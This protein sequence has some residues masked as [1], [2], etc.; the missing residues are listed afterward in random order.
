M[1]L[2]KRIHAIANKVL[3][4]QRVADI[5]TDHG[6]VPM[7]LVRNGVTSDVIM[8]DI[9]EGSLSKAVETFEMCKLDIE[10]DRFRVGDGLETIEEGEADCVIIAGL[11]GFT[12]I[13]ILSSSIDKAK[14]FDRLILQPRK[15]SGSLRYFLYANGWDIVCE[16]LAPEGKFFC[17]I[18]VAEPSDSAAPAGSSGDTALGLRTPPYPEDDIRWLYPKTMVT[19]SPYYA[20]KR[21][22]WKLESIRGEIDNLTKSTKDYS[23]L[24][25]KLSADISYLENLYKLAR[26]N[27]A[28]CEK[29][30][31]TQ[32]D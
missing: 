25:E 29:D 2:S 26:T 13:E 16:D 14:S 8:S 10:P 19:S 27:G 30:E 7:L 6:F 1:R 9:S 12:I 28:A 3:P 21:I 22:E 11:G 24:I 4:N 23:E 15:H 17:E 31:E 18:I 5:G 32:L 20:G